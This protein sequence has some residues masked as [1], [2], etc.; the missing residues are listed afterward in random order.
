METIIV[1]NC[2]RSLTYKRFIPTVTQIYCASKLLWI[3]YDLWLTRD[4]FQRR[5]STRSVLACCELL[6]IFDLQE[7]YSNVGCFVDF[8]VMV[9]NCLRSLTYKRFIP[10]SV[11]V[12]EQEKQLW[13]AYDLWLT[14]DLFQLGENVR[15]LVNCC[16]LLTIFDLQEIYSN[17][18]HTFFECT[19]VVNCLRSLTYK[20]FIPTQAFQIKSHRPLWIAYDLWLT[21]DLFQLIF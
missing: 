5:I 17:T 14:R 18:L 4:L 21:R 10:T 8:T 9:V 19:D 12:P 3:A 1:V 7:I 20:R 6:T 2:L 13:I 16:E 11:F 15:G